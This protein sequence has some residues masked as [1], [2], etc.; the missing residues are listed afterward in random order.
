MMG[1]FAHVPALGI[2]EGI[3]PSVPPEEASVAPEEEPEDDPEEEPPAPPLLLLATP[4]D[5]PLLAPELD[6]GPDPDDP[7]PLPEPLALGAEPSFELPP[8]LDGQLGPEFGSEPHEA[9]S[10]Q[11]RRVMKPIETSALA[12]IDANLSTNRADWPAGRD[13]PG[14][15]IF[16]RAREELRVGAERSRADRRQARE[17]ERRDPG[18][19]VTPTGTPSRASVTAMGGPCASRERALGGEECACG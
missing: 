1:I 2:P 11:P 6:P 5:E 18:G 16:G 8:L 9:F 13:S 19:S 17:R 12:L 15:G 10:V 3:E 4:L 7:E 14:F